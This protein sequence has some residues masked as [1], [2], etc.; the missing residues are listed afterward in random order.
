MTYYERHKETIKKNQLEY[1]YKNKDKIRVYN[2]EYYNKNK[3]RINQKNRLYWE[4]NFHDIYKKR[5]KNSNYIEYQREYY[6]NTKY[7]LLYYYE[8]KKEILERMK[9]YRHDYNLVKINEEDI[10]N[11][12][13]KQDN[14]LYFDKFNMNIKC[15]FD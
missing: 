2:R 6:N 12:H 8:N 13:L 1:Y 14:P 9:Q 15:Y 5:I 11:L 10:Y 7:G 3:E 4:N